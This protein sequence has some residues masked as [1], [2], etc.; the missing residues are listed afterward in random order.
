VADAFC[1]ARLERE[2]GRVYGTLPL[3]VD[4][5]AILDRALPE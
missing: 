3:G 2:A 4:S 5:K 1:A